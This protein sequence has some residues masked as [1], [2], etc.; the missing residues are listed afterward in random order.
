MALRQI[1]GT[2]VDITG[3]SVPGV[4]VTCD[5]AVPTATASTGA[6]VPG[7]LVTLTNGSGVWQFNL[8][9]NAD[10]TPANSS[11]IITIR[12][13]TVSS[14]SIVVPSTAYP[15][16][17]PT[18]FDVI[19]DGLIVA[20]PATPGQFITGPPGAAGAPGGGASLTSANTWTALQTFN[21][22][23]SYLFDNTLGAQAIFA[24][25]NKTGLSTGNTSAPL[26]LTASTVGNINDSSHDYNAGAFI[27]NFTKD[28]AGLVIG[29]TAYGDGIYIQT[30]DTAGDG[31]SA[32]QSN[33][34]INLSVGTSSIKNGS[35]DGFHIQRFGAGAAL[36]IV[37]NAGAGTSAIRA[38]QPDINVS[39]AS[40][41]DTGYLSLLDGGGATSNTIALTRTAVTTGNYL[42]LYHATS[43][44]TGDAVLM[45]L[46]NSGTFSGKFLHLLEAGAE[47]F[48]IDHNGTIN[49][50]VATG[51]NPLVMSVNGG[52]VTYWDSNGVLHPI[53]GALSGGGIGFWA[54]AI[55][56]SQPAAP[57]TLA[58]VIAVIRGC[59]LSA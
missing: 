17:H 44:Y 24:A 48:N 59:G 26:H 54:H 7:Q 29:N 58:D 20:I 9:A 15:G 50:N 53:N 10:L 25:A 56:G 14:F 8:Y 49:T 35:G 51:N 27:E 39:H 34:G 40:G 45:N 21:A 52:T 31:V 57:V 30:S 19:A 18:Y 43:T 47:R 16:G 22:G 55:P 32:S 3:T 36:S 1:Q 46:G 13:T 41:V 4:T 42:N 23:S 11:Y 38:L 2:V 5:L 6:V 33:W 12:H 37:T 28:G